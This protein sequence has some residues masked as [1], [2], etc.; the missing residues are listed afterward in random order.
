[1]KDRLYRS[2]FNRVIGGVASGLASYWNLDPVLVRV[3]FVIV[4]LM[5]GVGII[6]Y[7]ILWIVVPEE[8]FEMPSFGK[9]EPSKADPKDSETANQAETDKEFEAKIHDELD[10]RKKGGGRAFAG[11]LLISLGLLF[12]AERVFP[13][14]DFIDLLPLILIGTG[15]ILIFNSTRK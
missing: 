2:R 8:P 5:T 10:R 3:I 4:A 14:F 13:Y 11:I 6:L 15:L 7:I 1:M 12:F 9:E